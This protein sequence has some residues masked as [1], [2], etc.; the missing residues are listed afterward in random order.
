MHDRVCVAV[1][2]DSFHQQLL[3]TGAFDAYRVRTA[4]GASAELAGASLVVDA[5]DHLD[6]LERLVVVCCGLDAVKDETRTRSSLYRSVT[7]A[8]LMVVVVNEFLRGGWLEFLGSVRLKDERFDA[9]DALERC[10]LGAADDAVGAGVSAAVKALLPEACLSAVVAQLRR[11]ALDALEAGAADAGAAARHAIDAWASEVAAAAAA[12]ESLGVID[13]VLAATVALS[14]RKRQE[15]SLEGAARRVVDRLRAAQRAEAV[16]AFPIV[17]DTAR[18]FVVARFV[19]SEAIITEEAVRAQ[20]SHWKM[21]EAGVADRVLQ[22]ALET[23]RPL[24]AEALAAKALARISKLATAEV[25][26]LSVDSAFAE[27]VAA[28]AAAADSKYIRNAVQKALEPKPGGWIFAA[29]RGEPRFGPSAQKALVET[30]TAKNVSGGEEEWIAWTRAVDAEAEAAAGRWAKAE[31][32]ALYALEAA[33]ETAALD[34]DDHP[35]LAE[36]LVR[37]AF[38]GGELLDVNARAV[39]LVDERRSDGEGAQQRLARVALALKEACAARHLRPS[40]AA[41][42]ELRKKVL[43]AW[44]N[45]QDL[46]AAAVEAAKAYEASDRNNAITQTVW[47]PSGNSTG[48]A[49][50]LVKFMPFRSASQCHAIG[51]DAFSYVYTFLHFSLLGTVAR[52]CKRW[53]A[54]SQDPFWLPDVV[55]YA[56]GREGVSGLAKAASKPTLLDFSITRSVRAVVCAD[57]ATFAVCDDGTLYHW[58]RSWEP[59]FERQ[60]ARTQ[61]APTRVAGLSDVVSVACTPSGYYHGRGRSLGYTCAA[62]TAAGKLYTWGNNVYGQ[63]LQAAPAHLSRN[64]AD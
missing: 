14:L 57:D 62:L 13:A 45:G 42:D 1:P 30:V 41:G 20:L 9:R 53:R 52:V 40:L 34:G 46:H 37:E 4:A 21:I 60:E 38:V 59:D 64:P 48:K 3:E 10:Q 26:P 54:A 61:L 23:S 2:D 6:G 33:L 22:L 18:R 50:G 16:R 5:I 58:G 56:W 24:D 19:H 25:P 39:A 43:T 11:A 28:A 55:C 8:H 35:D 31:A 17:S 27:T 12:L 47:D 63:T 32:R 51:D 29:A 44:R 7:R 36:A 49:S 15:V